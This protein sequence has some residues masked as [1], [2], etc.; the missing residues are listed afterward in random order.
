MAGVGIGAYE[1][2]DAATRQIV[3]IKDIYSPDK[4][5]RPVY[6]ENFLKYRE[7]YTKLKDTF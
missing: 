3:R 2:Y 5:K 4:S 7:L 1:N 6:D